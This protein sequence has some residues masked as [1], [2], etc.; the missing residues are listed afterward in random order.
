MY[1]SVYICVHMNICMCGGIEIGLFVDFIQNSSNLESICLQKYQTEFLK[2]L[3][4]NN[5]L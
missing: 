2:K 4:R 1:K 3:I 5:Y